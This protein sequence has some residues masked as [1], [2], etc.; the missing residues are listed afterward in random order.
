[1]NFII[2]I[3]L[4]KI[5]GGGKEKPKEDQKKS[6]PYLILLTCQNLQEARHVHLLE[7]KHKDAW[8][9]SQ[10]KII[11]SASLQPALWGGLPLAVVQ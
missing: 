2:G 10:G 8:C 1:M 4:Y 7:G 3:K 5:V 9:T 6:V 11:A